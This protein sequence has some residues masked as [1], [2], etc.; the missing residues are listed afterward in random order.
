MVKKESVVQR[1]LVFN[2]VLIIPIVI[3]R[4]R[5][6]VTRTDLIDWMLAADPG[7]HHRVYLLAY[8]PVS[9]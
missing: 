2:V 4:D 8:L 1:K 6:D 7:S 9:R 3:G 5:N